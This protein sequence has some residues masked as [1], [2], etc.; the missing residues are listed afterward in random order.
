MATATL[1]HRAPAPTTSVDATCTRAAEDCEV[2]N[3]QVVEESP[4]GAREVDVATKLTMLIG[5]HVLANRLGRMASEGLFTLSE[6]PHLRRRPDVAFIS[7][8]RWPLDRAIAPAAAYEMIPDLVIE[9]ISPTDL[10]TETQGKVAEYFRAGVR[11]VWLA[12]PSLAQVCVYDTPSTSRIWGRADTIDGGDILPGL[13]LL[14]SQ[15]FEAETDGAS[16][17]GDR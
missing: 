17:E 6:D 4:L 12:F 2:V 15:V 16:T 11:Q 1:P 3:G 7:A 13:S 5:F 9:V 10:A 8:A 14:L